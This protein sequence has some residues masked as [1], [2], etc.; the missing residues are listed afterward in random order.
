MTVTTPNL[1]PG[2]MRDHVPTIIKLETSPQTY[3]G[4]LVTLCDSREWIPLYTLSRALGELDW[5]VMGAADLEEQRHINEVREAISTSITSLVDT[6]Y[7][8]NLSPL[9]PEGYDLLIMATDTSVKLTARLDMQGV[10]NYSQDAFSGGVVVGNIAGVT[11]VFEFKRHVV[12][13]ILVLNDQGREVVWDRSSAR[14]YTEGSQ[15]LNSLSRTTSV[16]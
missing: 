5:L 1:A 12:Q 6:H 10:A 11:I 9:L 7:P 13:R 3:L 16:T 15:C 4:K 14:V 8:I 2:A